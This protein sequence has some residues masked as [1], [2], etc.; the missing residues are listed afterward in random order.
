MTAA[1]QGGVLLLLLLFGLLYS[2]VPLAVSH[3]D[4]ESPNT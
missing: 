1:S 3:L 4:L 2:A